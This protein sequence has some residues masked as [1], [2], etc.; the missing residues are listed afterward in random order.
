VGELASDDLKSNIQVWAVG[1][2]N[3]KQ[4]FCGNLPP[5]HGSVFSYV[6]VQTTKR[7]DSQ[8]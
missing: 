8:S 6:H 3:I 2:K 5:H 7:G 1:A 4:V